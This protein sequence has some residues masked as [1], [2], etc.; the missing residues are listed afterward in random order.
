MAGISSKATGKLENRYKY[1][2]KQEQRQEFSDGSGLEWMD[3]GARMYD[4]QIGRWHVIDPLAE[5]YELFS[6]YH[7]AGNNSIRYRDVDGRYYVGTDGK[8]VTFTL[9]DGQI[10]FSDNASADLIELVNNTNASGS[11]TA[12]NQVMKTSQNKSKIHVKIETEVH[13][14]PNQKGYKLLGLHEAHDKDGNALIWNDNRGDFNGIPVYVE[15]EEGVYAEA[16]I[17]I[18]KANIEKSGGNGWYYGADVTV[19]QEMAN[20]FQHESNHNTDNVFIQDLKNRRE[21]KPNKGVDPH[22]N[23]RPQE[24]KVYKEMDNSNKK[25]KR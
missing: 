1:N 21:G 10:Q 4:A 12:I 19:S 20:T 23:I 16:T 13:D 11:A 7:F 9:V 25:K 14:K 8:A 5:K 15:G 22:D 17:T 2:G 6:P 24:K 18:F 3:Y